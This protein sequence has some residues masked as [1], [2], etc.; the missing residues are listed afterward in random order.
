MTLDWH[1]TPSINVQK[2][3][4]EHL[5]WCLGTVVVLFFLFSVFFFSFG[6]QAAV[7]RIMS[8]LPKE[9]HN[10]RSW[11]TTSVGRHDISIYWDTG[12]RGLSEM[13]GM[14]LYLPTFSESN[15]WDFRTLAKMS[16]D[17]A[18]ISEYFWSYLK[19]FRWL[20]HVLKCDILAHSDT[21]RT[22]T[23]H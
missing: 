17:V 13:W 3:A 4:C 10:F 5:A 1:Q 18:T 11:G 16:E 20:L 8:I 9:F 12:F 23:R 14:G 2:L 6:S 21:V 15:A 19:L 22:Q 7:A